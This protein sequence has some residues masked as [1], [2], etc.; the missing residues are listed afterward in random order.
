M[1][2]KERATKRIGIV[3]GKNTFENYFFLGFMAIVSHLLLLSLF[4]SVIILMS[5]VENTISLF[6]AEEDPDLD[7]F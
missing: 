1:P 4:V 7:I 6:N 2:V 3:C 5:I